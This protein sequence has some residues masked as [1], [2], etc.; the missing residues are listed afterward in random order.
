[1]DRY[2]PLEPTVLDGRRHSIAGH[3][4]DLL[5]HVRRGSDSARLPQEEKGGAG[6][7]PAAA[8]SLWRLVALRASVF[9][10]P[11]YLVAVS[12]ADAHAHPQ[13]R[14]RDSVLGDH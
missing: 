3:H 11:Y 10:R 12:D 6:R 4:L 2:V 7:S 13:Y 1:M 8:T 5:S 9:R 14:P